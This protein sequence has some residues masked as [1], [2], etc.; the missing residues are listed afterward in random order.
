MSETIDI[1]AVVARIDRDLMESRK[2][3]EESDKLAAEARKL[4]A[5]RDKLLVEM[6]KIERDRRLAPW[7]LGVAVLAA[8]IG[9]GT[10]LLTRL[11]GS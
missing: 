6:L 2:L 11:L 10:A 1:Q 5:E 9:A 8:L 7:V 4:S 3:R